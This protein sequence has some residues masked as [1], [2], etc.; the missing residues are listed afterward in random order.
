MTEVRVADVNPHSVDSVGMPIEVVYAKD[1]PQYAV[2][3]TPERVLVHF[4]DSPE[5][6]DR[7]RRDLT[8][9]NPLRGEINGLIN[10]WRLSKAEY[11]RVR[12]HRFDRRVADALTIGLQGDMVGATLLLER[13]R[14]DIIAERTSWARFLYLMIA[15]AVV[16]AIILLAGVVTADWFGAIYN[17]RGAG[18]RTWLAAGAGAFGAFFSIATAIR[19]RTI[20][21]DLRLRDNT[22][23]AVLRVVVG[24]IAGALLIIIIESETIRLQ[25]GGLG[26]TPETLGR[27][28]SLVILL[29]FI[30]G[31]SERLVS[32]LL[33]K[34]TPTEL[35][36]QA[37]VATATGAA[38][39]S[40][41]S[42]TPPT[43][44]AAAAASAAGTHE[45]AAETEPEE[46]EVDACLVDV[47][48]PQDELTDD[49]ELPESTGGVAEALPDATTPKPPR[50]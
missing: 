40:P 49:S 10:G 29:G 15:S 7:Q 23:D 9:L 43:I 11:Y 3:R 37:R 31:F 17:F 13:V 42:E 21:T 24:A 12:A 8:P 32:D 14:Q 50:P 45:G 25:I 34:V 46:E 27:N 4:A 1:V 20:L 48:V 35:A 36:V 2:Y 30:A 22:A 38:P 6:R 44:T 18:T 47:D 39:P 19:S 41:G 28:L 26:L 33:A 16:V 5:Q